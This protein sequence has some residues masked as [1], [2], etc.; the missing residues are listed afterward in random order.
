MKSSSIASLFCDARP[1]VLRVA[2]V[3]LASR[4]FPGFYREAGI[5]FLVLLRLLAWGVS[6]CLSTL[7]FW[8]D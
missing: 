4:G 8:T 1:L 6:S 2:I 3:L 7:I 5:V